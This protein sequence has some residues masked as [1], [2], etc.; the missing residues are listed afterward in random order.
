MHAD[1]L[2][3]LGEVLHVAGRRDEGQRAIRRACEL[4]DAKGNL[5]SAQRA[6]SLLAQ[7]VA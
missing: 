4:Y 7:H 3:D 2:V 6:A 5:V 1:A